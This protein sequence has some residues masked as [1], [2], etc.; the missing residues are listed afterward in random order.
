MIFNFDGMAMSAPP[1]RICKFY[2]AARLFKGKSAQTLRDRTTES[3]ISKKPCKVI[4][5]YNFRPSADSHRKAKPLELKTPRAVNFFN[6][7]A[8][9][10]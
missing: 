1:S 6:A 8:Q 2:A 5:E 9:N 3:T 4:V 7:R 10:A